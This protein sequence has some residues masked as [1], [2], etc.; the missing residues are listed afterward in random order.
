MRPQHAQGLSEETGE[1]ALRHFPRRHGKVAMPN[2]AVA[3]G[4]AVD[5]DIVRRIDERHGQLHAA[6]H[7]VYEP[8]LECIATPHPVMIEAPD[9]PQAT[10]RNS[11]RFWNSGLRIDFIGLEQVIN[12]NS[13]E[14][15]ELHIEE[16][17]AKVGDGVKG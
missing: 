8:N 9:V 7:L 4:E 13:R 17:W 5:R 14:S 2:G 10:D 6:E 1:L 3:R 11:I 16:L 12:L 15:G